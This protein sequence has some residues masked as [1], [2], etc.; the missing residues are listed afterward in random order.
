MK[1]RWYFNF[2][3][4]LFVIR[5]LSFY[6]NAIRKVYISRSF[7]K[8]LEPGDIIV[9]YRTASG[10]PAHYTSVT[11]TVGIVENVITE[12]SNLDT[13]IA[14]CRKRSVFSDSELA[15]YWNWKPNNRPFI[16]N[17]L[18]VHSFPKRR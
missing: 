2:D 15:K 3:L 12:I 14:V 10:G 7:E 16:V 6:R 11:T 18:Y 17:F 13:F 1:T 8:G 5:V 4:K 9:F